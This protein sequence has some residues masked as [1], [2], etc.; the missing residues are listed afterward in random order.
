MF[1]KI[2]L[3]LVFIAI[4][5]FSIL[6]FTGYHIRQ[7]NHEFFGYA[8]FIGTE[9]NNSY[10][11]VHEKYNDDQNYSIR[12][13]YEYKNNNFEKVY[14]YI[15]GYINLIH[16]EILSITEDL[17]TGNIV[18]ERFEIESRET[19]VVSYSSEMKDY[20]D[21]NSYFI[22]VDDND[23]VIIL[24]QSYS[25]TVD[26]QY[27][28]EEYI[29]VIDKKANEISKVYTATDYG[30]LDIRFDYS[31]L[32]VDEKI[33]IVANRTDINEDVLTIDYKTDEIT[34]E[35]VEQFGIVQ[36]INDK[37]CIITKDH[38]KN[39]TCRTIPNGKETAIIN[40]IQEKFPDYDQD[41]ILYDGEYLYFVDY[42]SID[43]YDLDGFLVQSNETS[44]PFNRVLNDDGELVFFNKYVQGN[45]FVRLVYDIAHYDIL[46][47][48]I[49]K[50]SKPQVV[51][52][53]YTDDFYGM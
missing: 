27:V 12:H 31:Y 5:L 15:N 40:L 18:F 4:G 42:T 49:T 17:E 48:V 37:Y 16:D 3:L 20:I 35:T 10:I 38:R 11:Q 45:I 24:A 7:E 34:L 13:I 32:L 46:E 1:K 29:Y 52:A 43:V 21:K 6:Y 53:D 36:Y 14:S 28:V 41:N 2:I 26:E 39:Y 51:P 44:I 25:Y 19:Q 30:E 33:V 22:V 23:D 50:K 9:N 47:N 8:Y